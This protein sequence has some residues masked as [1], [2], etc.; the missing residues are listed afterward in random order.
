MFFYECIFIL[1]YVFYVLY[2]MR[3]CLCVG[4]GGGKGGG[5]TVIT[6]LKGY[7]AQCSRGGGSLC[8][9]KVGYPGRRRVMKQGMGSE[10]GIIIRGLIILSRAMAF[11]GTGE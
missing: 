10:G 4:R 8:L 2:I 6:K 7:G 9:C 1:F 5:M 11:M 3:V